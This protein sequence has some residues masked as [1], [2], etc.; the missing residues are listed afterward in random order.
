MRVSLSKEFNI[1]CPACDHV[2]CLSNRYDAE[3][4]KVCD[5]WTE[6]RCLD[7]RCE[8]C[9]ERPESPSKAPD[10]DEA[11]WETE[12]AQHS[13]PLVLGERF[14][15]TQPKTSRNQLCPCG[16]G[17]KHKKCCL[18][19]GA[20]PPQPP[21]VKK[22]VSRSGEHALSRF[23]RL[24]HGQHIQ[25]QAEMDY[26]RDDYGVPI[27]GGHSWRVW[28]L[29][30]Q[31]KEHQRNMRTLAEIRQ[32]FGLT[33]F[34]LSEA[35]EATVVT[36]YYEGYARTVDRSH[37]INGLSLGAERGQSSSGTDGKRSS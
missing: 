17:K 35:E 2:V 5:G 36:R 24:F 12:E 29:G 11:T 15:I 7:G 34:P 28:W 18:P 31:D 13:Q 3:F 19:S 37:Q 32:F 8:F 16:S 14:L 21:S 25:S 9:R 1:R 33:D 26:P 6:E 27:I 20:C 22:E 10:L 30:F 23:G 4:C